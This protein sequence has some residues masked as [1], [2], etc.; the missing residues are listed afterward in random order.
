MAR[1]I[2]KQLCDSLYKYKDGILYW[3]TSP[4]PKIK[5]GNPVGSLGKDGYFSTTINYKK[6]L[7][8]RL[9]FLMHHGYLPQY[10]DHIN[11]I[12]TDNRIENLRQT[13]KSQNNYNSK[14]RVSNTSGVKNVHWNKKQKQWVVSLGVNKKIKYCGSFDD[15][16]L[17]DLV[18]TEARNKYHKQFANHGETL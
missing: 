8:H 18:A 7:N 2:T 3:K 13:N 9:I 12:P 4:S 6:Y 15:F 5:I 11:N 10:I 16:E 14:L 1:L 17:A